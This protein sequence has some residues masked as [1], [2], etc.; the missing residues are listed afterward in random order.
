MRYLFFILT[1]LAGLV[2]PAHAQPG[3]PDSLHR[4]SW[5]L[6]HHVIGQ[7]AGG[8]GMATVGL[9]YTSRRR[10]D[11]DLLAG[12][13]P[14][15]YSITPMGIFTAKATYSPWLV[16][17]GQSRWQL[18]PLSAGGMLS[19]TASKGFNKTWDDKYSTGYYW[20]SAHTRIGGFVGGRLAY[21]LSNQSGRPARFI[22]AYY[23][24]GTNDLYL[25]SIWH[26]I[27][28]LPLRS[29]LTLGVG[30]KVDLF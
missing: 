13:V 27:G 14:R 3:R 11:L 28:H 6:P 1:I 19:Y 25:V 17:L 8:Q 10:L 26:N 12:Y 22:S 29:I 20:W 18:R 7:F 23:E 16:S 15:R 24:L 21:R 9:G 5:L 30:V 4:R 2:A